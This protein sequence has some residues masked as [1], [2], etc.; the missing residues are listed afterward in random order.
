VRA[1]LERKPAIGALA[2]L[3]EAGPCRSVA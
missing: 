3:S 2:T 1:Y